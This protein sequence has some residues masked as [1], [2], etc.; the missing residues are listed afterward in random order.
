M[1]RMRRW[2]GYDEGS[3][4]KLQVSSVVVHGGDLGPRPR[5]FSP[6]RFFFNGRCVLTDRSPPPPLEWL[7]FLSL[8]SVLFITPKGVESPDSGRIRVIG[9]LFFFPIWG[10]VRINFTLPDRPTSAHWDVVEYSE[11]ADSVHAR[12][13]SNE[14]TTDM[15]S[16]RYSPDDPYYRLGSVHTCF[17][18]RVHETGDWDLLLGPLRMGEG[19]DWWRWPMGVIAKGIPRGCQGLFTPLSLGYPLSVFNKNCTLNPP[20]PARV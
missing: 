13:W 11:V 5:R 6:S 19:G 9:V 17:Y 4:F 2:R 20:S 15:D 12:T 14:K 8:I 3:G 16:L 18:V 7:P 1:P 10:R